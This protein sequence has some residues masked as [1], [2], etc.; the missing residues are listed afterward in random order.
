MSS[1]EGDDMKRMMSG[2]FSEPDAGGTVEASDGVSVYEV[3]QFKGSR[4]EWEC[5]CTGYRTLNKECKHI[6]AVR[7]AVRSG[8]KTPK[9]ISFF[10]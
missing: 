7:D 1:E 8:K 4:K 10:G 6:S 3:W 2:S 9:V 5:T